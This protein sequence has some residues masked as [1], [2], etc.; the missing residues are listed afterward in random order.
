MKRT[1]SARD[2]K[3]AD[4]ALHT[5]NVI[6]ICLAV[7]HRFGLIIQLANLKQMSD[8][9]VIQTMIVCPETSAGMRAPKLIIKPVWK[10]MLLLMVLPLIGTLS[11][12][13]RSPKKLFFSTVNYASQALLI[14]WDQ[15]PQSASKSRPSNSMEKSL[16]LH[17]SVMPQLARAASM[18]ITH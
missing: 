14:S 16:N 18:S 10:N 1:V 12:I 15:T 5:N 4:P 2:L 13:P 7:L 8:L 6:L 9:F 3:K 17:M 11:F